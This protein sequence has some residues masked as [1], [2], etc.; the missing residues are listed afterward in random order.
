MRTVPAL[1]DEFVLGHL[2]RLVAANALSEPSGLL[3]AFGSGVAGQPHQSI[4]GRARYYRQLASILGMT[5]QAYKERHTLVLLTKPTQPEVY[6]A[7]EGFLADPFVRHHIP[8]NFMAG[9][10]KRPT[11]WKFCS[12]CRVL[13]R[14]RYGIAYW[15]RVHQVPGIDLCPLHDEPL[16]G[17][18]VE[19]IFQ[20]PTLSKPDTLQSTTPTPELIAAN[21]TPA[22]SLYRAVV[23]EF[24][25]RPL[26][27]GQL[28][29]RLLALRRHSWMQSP[30][31]SQTIRLPPL[32]AVI[33]RHEIP[34]AWI[35]HHFP[36][37]RKQWAPEGVFT[38]KT[39]RIKFLETCHHRTSKARSDLWTNGLDLL[40]ACLTI[41][42]LATIQE[43][44]WPSA[45]SAAPG[46]AAL[47]QLPC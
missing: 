21:R 5:E 23:A 17:C 26:P 1:P 16:H 3:K 36:P 6:P 9:D 31:D 41:R 32:G 27:E 14:A 22:L 34:E 25:A 28:R 30:L 7:D 4:Q 37:I 24:L 10:T 39:W 18:A 35:A 8:M 11:L 44:L 46:Q 42:D 43:V 40:R 47:E 20:D 2:T 45:A 19:S 15:H 29:L 12:T 13:D 33:S 38:D